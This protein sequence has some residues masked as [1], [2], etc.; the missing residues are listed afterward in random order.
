M[1]QSSRNR[2]FAMS[3]VSLRY[4]WGQGLSTAAHGREPVKDFIILTEFSRCQEGLFK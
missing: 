3:P 4:G 1:A 2:T